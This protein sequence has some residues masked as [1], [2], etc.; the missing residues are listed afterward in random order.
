MKVTVATLQ[1]IPQ[2]CGLLNILF[3]QEVEFAPNHIAQTEGLTA[4]ISSP[5]VGDILLARNGNQIVGMLSLLF[6]ISTAHGSRVALLEDMIVT[7]E[8]RRQ[9]VG[10]MLIK[11][12]IQFAKERGCSRV[13]LLTDENNKAAHTFYQR[14]GFSKSSMV[15]FRINLDIHKND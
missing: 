8:A 2:L 7:P 6:T 10:S 12:A 4:I 11:Y 5:E 3:T 9:G 1:D 15:P 13:T 14:H